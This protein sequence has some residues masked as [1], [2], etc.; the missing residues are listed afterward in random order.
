MKHI[1]LFEELSVQQLEDVVYVN[2]TF[3]DEEDSDTFKETYG[4]D[5]D[6]STKKKIINAEISYANITEVLFYLRSVYAVKDVIIRYKK[7]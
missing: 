3:G 1:K 7:L 6:N 4:G 5:Y 2:V